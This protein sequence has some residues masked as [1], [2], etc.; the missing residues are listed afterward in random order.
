MN[1][2]NFWQEYDWDLEHLNSI[3]GLINVPVLVLQ[4]MKKFGGDR[5]II[6]ICGPMTSGGFGKYINM[7]IFP[8]AIDFAEKQGLLVF[9]Q[10]PLQ[11]AMDRIA[12]QLQIK[13][14]S[15]DHY[16]EIVG[17]LYFGIFKKHLIDEGWFL[18]K[19]RTSIGATWEYEMMESLNITI[20][21]YPKEW[22]KSIA[23]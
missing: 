8:R 10:M 9:N 2:P 17:K 18:P 19:W 1:N 6:I 20:R 7:K 22:F 21:D 11:K 3:E 12:K 14:G 4:K 15:L 16:R 13:E 5:Q 23:L